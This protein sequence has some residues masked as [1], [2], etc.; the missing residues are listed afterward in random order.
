MLLS[1]FK[2]LPPTIGGYVM[3]TE[4][5]LTDY[6]AQNVKYAVHYILEAPLPDFSI[7]VG[8]LQLKFTNMKITDASVP[9]P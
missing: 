2:T 9:A 5:G 7:D 1:T 4:K 6:V 3:L 8:L